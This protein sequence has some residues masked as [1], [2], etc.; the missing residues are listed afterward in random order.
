M[1]VKKPLLVLG[2]GVGVGVITCVVYVLRRK[3]ND[4]IIQTSNSNRF[5]RAIKI[6]KG[7]VGLVLGRGGETIKNIREKS[8]AR[9]TLNDADGYTIATVYG[10]VDQVEEAINLINQIMSN[11]HATVVKEISL[12]QNITESVWKNVNHIRQICDIT[13]ATIMFEFNSSKYKNSAVKIVI[14]GKQ[15]E[16][17]AAVNLIDEL[18]AEVEVNSCKSVHIAGRALPENLPLPSSNITSKALPCEKLIPNSSD[19]FI[20]V[21][22]SAVENPSKFWVQLSGSKS[23]QLDKLATEM[24]EFYSDEK[25]KVKWQLNT[26]RAGDI[27][28]AFFAGD[29]SWYRAQVVEVSNGEKDNE[30]QIHVFYLDFGDSAVLKPNLIAVLK[31]DFLSIPFQAIECCLA[32]VEPIKDEWSLEASEEFEKLVYL[33]QWKVIMAKPINKVKE[34]GFTSSRDSIEW[35]ELIDTNGDKN[36]NVAEELVLKGYAKFI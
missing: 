23:I 20:E 28:A 35:V 3:K 27:V 17:N 13:R 9:I 4:E 21:F 22:I 36:I 1:W 19:G 29:N 11:H 33:A 26:I 5:Q 8:K 25:S 12:T 31:P 30:K 34:N 2:I 24:T 18:V 14:K 6:P 7:F 16:V 10:S 32:D 15:E